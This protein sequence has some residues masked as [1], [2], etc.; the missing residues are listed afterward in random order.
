MMGRNTQQEIQKIMQKG[1]KKD[2]DELPD[3]FS[4]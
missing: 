2:H 3:L 1:R 4:L